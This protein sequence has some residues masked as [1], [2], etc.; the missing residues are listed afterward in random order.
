MSTRTTKP[1]RKSEETVAL[2]DL[3]TNMEKYISRISEGESFTI[4]RRSKPIFKIS[5]LEVDDESQWETVFDFTS[6]HKNGVPVKE[7]L[8]AIKRIDE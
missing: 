6:I 4:I 5:P 7:V 1:I 3:R 8:D 2:K